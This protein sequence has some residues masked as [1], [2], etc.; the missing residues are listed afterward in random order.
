MERIRRSL[1]LPGLI[2]L[3]VPFAATSS[4]AV[5]MPPGSKKL[6][7]AVGFEGRSALTATCT[8]Q[9]RNGSFETGT[10]M[11]WTTGGSPEVISTGGHTVSHSALLG[12]TNNDY[13][14]IS[15]EVVCPYYGDKVI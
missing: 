5:G 1:I 3:L 12:G 13:D 11:Y 6:I 2:I 9:I 4:S 14:E 15:Q 10:F 8:D 7:Q